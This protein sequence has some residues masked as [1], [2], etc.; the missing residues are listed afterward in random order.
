MPAGASLGL[1]IRMLAYSND[2]VYIG[3]TYGIV[4]HTIRSDDWR[5]ASGVALSEPSTYIAGALSAL[6]IRPEFPVLPDEGEVV[7]RKRLGGL[8]RYYHR[9]AAWS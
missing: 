7:C 8:L 4:G 3:E 1:P 6:P 9:E 2:D 5:W